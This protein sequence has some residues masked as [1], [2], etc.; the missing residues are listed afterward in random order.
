MSRPVR[1]VLDLPGGVETAWAVLAGDAWPAALDAALHDGSELVSCEP[2]ADGGR[3]VV[4]RRRLPEPPAFLSRVA[5]MDG[6]VTQTDRW[7]P[8]RDGTRG[9]TW[10]VASPG[11]P[12]DVRGEMLLEP[13]G[14]GC[15]WTV[16]GTVSVAIPLLGG[17]AESFLAPLVERLVARQGEVLRGRLA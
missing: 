9:G 17:R 15:R 16:T 8:A 12:G 5:P 6:R 1:T 11:S 2:T 4:V 3:V 7:G 14:S 13:A 10:E